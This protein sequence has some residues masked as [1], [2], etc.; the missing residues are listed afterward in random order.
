M[1]LRQHR[2]VIYVADGNETVYANYPRT[3]FYRHM[4]FDGWLD[5]IYCRGLHVMLICAEPHLMGDEGVR[6]VALGE[7]LNSFLRF[8]ELWNY[9]TFNFV[10]RSGTI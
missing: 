9:I 1:L 10:G 8:N 4:L 5:P 6:N 2:P 3:L 7:W